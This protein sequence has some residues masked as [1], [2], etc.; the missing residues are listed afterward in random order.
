MNRA[1]LRAIPVLLLA[2]LAACNQARSPQK[3]NSDVARAQ[4][5]AAQQTH[6]ADKKVAEA[7]YD[8]SVA[9]AQARH[10]VAIAKCEALSGDAHKAC[11]DQADAALATAKADAESQRVHHE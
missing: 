2:S 8:A 7:S 11:T 5:S 4:K 9:D 3:V 6:S 1:L 10:K